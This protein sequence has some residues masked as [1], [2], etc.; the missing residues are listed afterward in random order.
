MYVCVMC[1]GV[2]VCLQFQ[3]TPVDSYNLNSHYYSLALRGAPQLGVVVS[4]TGQMFCRAEGT[5]GNCC[6][7]FVAHAGMLA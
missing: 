1:V 2:C 4:L 6:Q 3:S 5:S 7:Q